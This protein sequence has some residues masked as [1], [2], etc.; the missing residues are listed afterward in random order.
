[1]NNGE[2]R[3]FSLKDQKNIE[4]LRKQIFPY[5]LISQGFARVVSDLLLTSEKSFKQINSQ[6]HQITKDYNRNVDSKGNLTFEGWNAIIQ[7]KIRSRGQDPHNSLLVH[8]YWEYDM[9]LSFNIVFLIA[10][11]KYHIATRE[12]RFIL[13]SFVHAFCVDK[14][15]INHS[16]KEKLSAIEEDN[17]KFRN[18][19]RL[20]KEFFQVFID[21]DGLGEELYEFYALLCGKVH[22]SFEE[23]SHLS[24]TIAVHGEKASMLGLFDFYNEESFQEI[25]EY[26]SLLHKFLIT[27][28]EVF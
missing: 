7:K 11:A 3:K 13:E 27:I 15:Y 16:L 18:K 14:I 17:R 22:P 24:S 28:L 23:L 26:F 6:C 8:R 2:R 5:Y 1:M 12:I 25:M 19:S 4:I 20:F 21:E 9:Q 10:S